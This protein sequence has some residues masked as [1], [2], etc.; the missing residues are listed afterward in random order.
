MLIYPLNALPWTIGGVLMAKVS[1]K[2]IINFLNLP[3]VRKK[4]YIEL[5]SNLFQN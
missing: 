3:E 2:R 4:N 1:F 5:D